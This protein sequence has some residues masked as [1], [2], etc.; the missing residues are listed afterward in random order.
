MNLIKRDR[1]I[2]DT[3]VGFKTTEEKRDRLKYIAENI[4]NTTVSDIL[5][6]IIENIIIEHDG[7][8]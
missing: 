8:I 3:T 1:A 5:D 2:K 7:I 6:Q 4:Y